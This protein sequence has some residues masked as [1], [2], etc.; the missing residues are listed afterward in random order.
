MRRREYT[1]KYWTHQISHLYFQNFDNEVQNGEALH[2]PS[3][4]FY[5]SQSFLF[6]FLMMIMIFTTI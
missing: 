5:T 1:L 3:I 4:S 6:L 2:S